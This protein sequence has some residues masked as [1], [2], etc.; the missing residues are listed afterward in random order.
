MSPII[1]FCC[2]SRIN[3][4]FGGGGVPKKYQV[5]QKVQRWKFSTFAN[6]C[7]LLQ[8][9]LNQFKSNLDRGVNNIFNQ[10]WS[11]SWLCLWLSSWPWSLV[12]VMVIGH[13]HGHPSGATYIFPLMFAIFNAVY[14]LLYLYVIRF[15][16]SL[17]AKSTLYFILT[18][19]FPLIHRSNFVENYSNYFSR[20]NHH[21][22][23]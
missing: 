13:S 1:T 4:S 14:W 15:R 17:Y 7:W 19:L 21:T 9:A 18:T 12:M 11:W 10:S 2:R 8:V 23:G 22:E 16:H 6:N 20:Y 5:L 3:R